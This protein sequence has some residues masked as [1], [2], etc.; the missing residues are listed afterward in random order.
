MDSMATGD[1]QL[2]EQHQIKEDSDAAED[3][4]V[5]ILQESD[6]IHRVDFLGQLQDSKLNRSCVA[7]AF[8]V[9]SPSSAQESQTK[10][11]RGAGLCAIAKRVSAAVYLVCSDLAIAQESDKREMMVR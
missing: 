3:V 2:N 10:K 9:S 7:A 8:Q 11:P 4:A 1:Y 5:D 6:E